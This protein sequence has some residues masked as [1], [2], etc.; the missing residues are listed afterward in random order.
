[1]IFMGTY[2]EFLE[3]AQCY[4]HATRRRAKLGM[5]MCLAGQMFGTSSSRVPPTKNRMTPSIFRPLMIC[6]YCQVYG[7]TKSTC[8]RDLRACFRCGSIDH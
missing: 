6:E 8:R 7:H 1:M 2:A 3:I 5:Q 4:E